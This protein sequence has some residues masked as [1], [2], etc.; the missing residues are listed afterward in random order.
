MKTPNSTIVINILLG[1]S[2]IIFGIWL[3]KLILKKYK[4]KTF[5]DVKGISVA[6]ASVLGGL[7]LIIKNLLEV[8]WVRI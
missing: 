6:L 2:L 1:I 5:Y 3:F 4:V 8:F 7:F